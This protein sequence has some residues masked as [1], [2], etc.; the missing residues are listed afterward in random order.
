[1]EKLNV[2]ELA[3]LHDALKCYLGEIRGCQQKLLKKNR[4]VDEEVSKTESLLS[5]V[6]NEFLK[7]G[8]S[9]NWL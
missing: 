4:H 9:S 1:M 6:H 5:R 3:I 7:Q 2:T 8:G